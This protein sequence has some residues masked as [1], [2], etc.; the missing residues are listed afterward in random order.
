MKVILKPGETVSICFAD[1]EDCEI[2][3][4]IGVL[5]NDGAI[6]IYTEWPDSSGIKELIYQ[7]KFSV[8]ETDTEIT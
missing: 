6:S 4:E 3:R 1:D 5:F 8:P 7:E 2:D